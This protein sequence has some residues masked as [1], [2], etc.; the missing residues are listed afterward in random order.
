MIKRSFDIIF[1]ILFSPL[2]VALFFF[3]F[4]LSL[5]FNKREIFFFQYR[6]GYKGKRIKIIKFRTMENKTKKI[7]SFNNFLRKV[8]FDEIPQFLNVV[9][10]DLSIVGPRPLHYEYKNI[11]SSRQNKR[12]KVKPGLTGLAQIQ[13]SHSMS[14]SKQFKIDVWYVENHNFFLDIKIIIK[15]LFVIMKSTSKKEIKDKKKFNGSN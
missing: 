6:G 5:I 13:D 15:T 10:G 9:K 3:I 2:I 1:V 4:I 12:F 8:R 14:W 11:Y 7:S